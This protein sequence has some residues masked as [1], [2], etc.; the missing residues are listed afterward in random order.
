MDMAARSAILA[1]SLVVIALAAAAGWWMFGDDWFGPSNEADRTSLSAGPAPLSDQREGSL[2][3]EF[4]ESGVWDR[5][6][7]D[8]ITI[9]AGEAPDL[10]R[11]EGRVPGAAAPR[12][13]PAAGLPSGPRFAAGSRGDMQPIDVR[14]GGLSAPPPRTSAAE[15]VE[16]DCRARGGGSYACRCLA[17]L[18]RSALTPAQFEFL[19]LAEEL[20]PRADRL[21][22]AGLDLNALPRL[23]V[24]L[25]ALDAQ[26]RRRCG[27]GLKP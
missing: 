27:A 9:R 19:S 7:E 10:Y 11:D 1:A 20:E 16:A 2:Y 22:T 25:V 4:G 15:R 26:A 24:A 18:A 5:T 13:G 14:P 3:D 23:A 6:R 17:R 21:A 8:R 12:E